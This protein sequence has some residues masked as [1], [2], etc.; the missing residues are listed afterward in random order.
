MRSWIN[1][2]IVYAFGISQAVGLGWLAAATLA[3]L[4]TITGIAQ[5][6]TPVLWLASVPVL[7]LIWVILYVTYSAIEMQFLF[8]N[9]EK[10]RHVAAGGQD[11]EGLRHLRLIVCYMRGY[12][13]KSLPMLNAISFLPGLGQLCLLAYA[14]RLR[15]G[16]RSFLAGFLYD[17]DLTEIGDDVVI[18]GGSV[19]SAHSMTM[20]RPGEFVYVSAKIQIANGVTI[21][22]E[23]RVAM[24]VTMGAHS[25][26]EPAS[27]VVAFTAIPPGE[28]WGGNPAVFLRKRVDAP[29]DADGTASQPS[30]AK[31]EFKV[32][33]LDLRGR[34]PNCRRN[35]PASQRHGSRRT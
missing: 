13:V 8:W 26:V 5:W 34:L 23:S 2:L 29:T 27:N 21:G 3:G 35:A 7:Y 31:A 30:R 19:I 25:I 24:G 11:A 14:P 10:P 4:L 33:N 12:L 15:I 20:K 32:Q 1:L 17:P 16:E 9:Y 28:V 22:G 6:L 18:G